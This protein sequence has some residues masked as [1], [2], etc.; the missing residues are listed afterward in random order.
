MN[1]K[2]LK[3]LVA[4]CGVSS[5]TASGTAAGAI[6][7]I[8]HHSNPELRA[9]VLDSG[10]LFGL[11]KQLRNKNIPRASDELMRLHAISALCCELDRQGPSAGI[12]I[13]TSMNEKSMPTLEVIRILALV[14]TAGTKDIVISG[15]CAVL[16]RLL[17]H[18][19]I[20]AINEIGTSLT[21]VDHRDCIKVGLWALC[22]V[23]RSKNMT[24]ILVPRT[25]VLQKEVNLQHTKQNL[26]NRLIHLGENMM[27]DQDEE[28]E[29][30]VNDKRQ[31]QIK[32]LGMA[33]WNLSSAIIS[34][35]RA[36]NGTDQLEN[37]QD[38][39]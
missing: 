19:T 18:S 5:F 22:A 2:L 16:S 37:N 27:L 10:A 32:F 15:A 33:F 28:E 17:P 25:V 8:I 30:K 14:C 23:A 4:A 20:A 9:M 29:K 39:I 13:L 3:G 1:G 38:F 26:M 12:D 21:Y 31:E 11:L 36:N 6:S 34:E 24:C 7:Q 35:H